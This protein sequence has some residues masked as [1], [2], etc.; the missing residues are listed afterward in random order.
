MSL[1]RG[2]TYAGSQSLLTTLWSVNDATTSEIMRNFY[3][4]LAA[5]LPKDQALYQAKLTHVEEK[6]QLLAHPFYWAGYTLMGDP[7]PLEDLQK[8][9]WPGWYL[10]V[11]LVGFFWLFVMYRSQQQLKNES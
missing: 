6:D 11:A 3:Q 7:H 9:T 4:G 5:G 8:S 1:A 10:L 2:F